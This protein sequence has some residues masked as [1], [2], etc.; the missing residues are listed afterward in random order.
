MDNKYLKLIEEMFNAQYD[1]YDSGDLLNSKEYEDKIDK[2]KTY[3]LSHCID[4]TNLDE[5]NKKIKIDGFSGFGGFKVGSFTIK[6]LTPSI[7]NKNISI[8]IYEKLRNRSI[9]TKI[10][11]NTDHRF[12]DT[13]WSSYF[14]K[15]AISNYGTLGVDMPYQIINEVVR[16]LEA[17]DKLGSFI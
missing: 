11:I 7:K 14:R 4:L 12:A 6:I 10:N 3:N 1:E 9:Q 8:F 17:L 16:W 13:T 15:G 2:M 5:A